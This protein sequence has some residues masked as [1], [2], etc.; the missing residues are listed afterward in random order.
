[1]IDEKIQNVDFTVS[2]IPV[3]IPSA[4]LQ[5]NGSFAPVQVL[6]NVTRWQTEIL[7]ADLHLEGFE[8][9]K[10]FTKDVDGATIIVTLKA[11]CLPFSIHQRQAHFSTGLAWRA[12]DIGFDLSAQD[13]QLQWPQSSWEIDAITC[14]GPEGFGEIVQTEVTNFLKNPA[15]IESWLK[16]LMEQKLNSLLA[17]ALEPLKKPVWLD[18]SQIFLAKTSQTQ[19]A[20][21]QGLVILFAVETSQAFQSPGASVVETPLNLAGE[22]WQE[23]SDQPVL[24]LPQ[25][26][27]ETTA[28]HAKIFPRVETHLNDVPAFAKILKSRFLQFFFWP[29]LRKFRKDAPF[30][31]TSLV[32][33]QQYAFPANTP[34]A[35]FVGGQRMSVKASISTWVK[36]VR[37]NVEINWAYINTVLTGSVKYSLIK[38]EMNFALEN[39]DLQMTAQHSTEYLEKYPNKHKFPISRVRDAMASQLLGRSFKFTLPVL[40]LQ[41]IGAQNQLRAKDLKE[42]GRNMIFSFEP[43]EF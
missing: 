33:G 28:R 31:A 20:N 40:D 42:K 6:Q 27:F 17:K 2:D 4:H 15:A 5:V 1:M 37:D 7:N 12:V 22:L 3:H 24:I 9:E 41:S 14:E 36:A 30:D 23:V 18:N 8:V 10:E 11:K 21:D 32:Q 26:F 19:V 13:L 38:G 43:I 34:Q 35:Q 29:E 16:P 25:G 39:P